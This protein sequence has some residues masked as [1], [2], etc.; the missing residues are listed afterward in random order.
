[1]IMIEGATHYELYE[2]EKFKEVVT[3]QVEWFR[4]YLK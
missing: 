2:G 4:K 1:L 3:K